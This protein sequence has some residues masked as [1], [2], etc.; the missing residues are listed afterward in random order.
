M[1]RFWLVMAGLCLLGVP[2][3]ASAQCTLLDGPVQD[4]SGI[5]GGEGGVIDMQ[6]ADTR[7]VILRSN[8]LPDSRGGIAGSAGLIRAEIGRLRFDGSVLIAVNGGASSGAQTGG[9]GGTID[10]QIERGAGVDDITLEANGGAGS[11]QSS[12]GDGGSITAAL[13]NVRVNTLSAT[14]TGETGGTIDIT[15]R[16]NTH[17]ASLAADGGTI[18]VDVAEEAQVRTLNVANGEP[19]SAVVIYTAGMVGTILTDEGDVIEIIAP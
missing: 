5:Y 12:G 19:G 16:G 13:N 2:G 9:R 18:T 8:G 1:Q 4:C 17:V 15:L 11:S 10:L 14:A 7:Q 6:I 3:V